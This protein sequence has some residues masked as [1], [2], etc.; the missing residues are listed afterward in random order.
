M[1][2]INKDTTFTRKNKL[3]ALLVVGLIV[4]FVSP[5]PSS[6][7][8][9]PISSGELPSM[10]VGSASSKIPATSIVDW[11]SYTD[12]V[13]VVTVI[14]E[15]RIA[16]NPNDAARGEGLVGREV[17][18]RID[19]NLWN[20]PNAPR[21]SDTVSV[22]VWGWVLRGGKEIPF[23]TRGETRVEVGKTY[24]A[25]LVKLNNFLGVEWAILANSGST[26]PI[27]DGI[28]VA[29]EFQ[30]ER[31]GAFVKEF[32]GLSTTELEAILTKAKPDPVASLHMNLDPADRV[33]RVFGIGVEDAENTGN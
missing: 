24:V 21:V 3:I 33:K 7:T 20:R 23:T 1:P 22:R 32:Q 13:S 29:P 27:E 28:I 5:W 19:K 9:D 31:V 16:A 4:L 11:V 25:P 30:P 10:V 8:T 14:S 17:V 12:Q 15:N 18:L 6:R 26:M 2:L